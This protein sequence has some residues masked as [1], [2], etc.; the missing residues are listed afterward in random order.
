[1]ET[2]SQKRLRRAKRARNGAH[3]KLKKACRKRKADKALRL[4]DVLLPVETLMF[5]LRFLT[6]DELESSQH[7]HRKF[8]GAVN[9]IF[10]AGNVPTRKIERIAVAKSK[11]D[12]PTGLA[13]VL[14]MDARRS[15]TDRGVFCRLN[16][17][18]GVEWLARVVRFS[19]VEVVHIGK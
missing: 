19:E 11:L 5:L 3:S 18:P 12:C 10:S 9:G 8:A 7:V 2:R 17:L 4:D 13:S 14:C 16:W 6:R 1:M 15:P